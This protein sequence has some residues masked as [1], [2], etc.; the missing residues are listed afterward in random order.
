MG[1]GELPSSSEGRFGSPETLLAKTVSANN[2]IFAFH[3]LASRGKV[4]TL[5]TFPTSQAKNMDA[6]F[7]ARG[8]SGS[9][10]NPLG[11][12]KN[13][14]SVKPA[15]PSAARSCGTLFFLY[16]CN[17]FFCYFSQGFNNFI[18]GIITVIELFINKIIGI[19]PY[20]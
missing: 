17:I 20:P 13:D 6:H 12:I 16:S 19:A 11:K 2:A 15:S 14:F 10:P 1:M 9:T 5:G 8:L 4:A 18:G 3:N 7:P